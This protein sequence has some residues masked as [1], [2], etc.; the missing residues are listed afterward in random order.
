MEVSRMVCLY[1]LRR[2]D[3]KS[4]FADDSRIWT[5]TMKQFQFHESYTPLSCPQT[6]CHM[7][8]TLGAGIQDGELFELLAQHNAIGVGG[9]NTVWG[10]RD[11]THVRCRANRI[12]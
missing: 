10:N 12:S 8:A 4:F 3:D 7:A 11:F 2:K 1:Y 5:H 6:V 9:T